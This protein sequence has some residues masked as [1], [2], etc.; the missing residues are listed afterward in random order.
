MQYFRRNKRY[1]KHVF[2][3]GQRAGIY[4]E[5]TQIV[6]QSYIYLYGWGCIMKIL[7]DIF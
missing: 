2:K 3:I 6:G 1:S 4:E 5:K 7:S